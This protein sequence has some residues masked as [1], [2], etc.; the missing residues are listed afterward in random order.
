MACKVKDF[1]NNIQWLKEHGHPDVENWDLYIEVL[2]YFGPEKNLS[3]DEAIQKIDNC[4]YKIIYYEEDE[5]WTVIAPTQLFYYP[6]EREAKEAIP[7]LKQRFEEEKLSFL[8]TKN[9][10]ETMERA[11]WKTWIDPEGTVHLEVADS[12]CNYIGDSENKRLSLNANY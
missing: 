6:T 5:C 2:G 1:L 12:Q 11:G 10:I 3:I 9:Y 7:E 4:E 8:K